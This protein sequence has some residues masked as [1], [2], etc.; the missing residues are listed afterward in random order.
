MYA[1]SVICML[2]T[3]ITL[4]GIIMVVRIR[5]AYESLETIF[6]IDELQFDFSP[7]LYRS[8]PKNV[9][10]IGDSLARGVGATD[11]KSSIS[12]QIHH[13]FGCKVTTIALI[14][15]TTEDY[16]F[17]HI[18]KNI[19]DN[20]D[21]IVV[22]LGGNDVLRLRSTK[23]IIRDINSIC[24][25]LKDRCQ[26]IVWFFAGNVGNIPIVNNIVPLPYIL[27]NKSDSVNKSMSENFNDHEKVTFIS[28]YEKEFLKTP[29]KK[30]S[31]SVDGLHPSNDVYVHRYSNEIIKVI[32]Q[33]Y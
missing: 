30:E 12:Y 10:V 14:G 2:I 11:S 27:R 26:H 1:P 25:I 32:N 31:F 20:Y 28:F 4:L 22:S 21:V 29:L 33:M 19:L 24:S 9:L 7:Q 17:K 23:D 13:K 3:I 5:K 6:K 8:G 15:A 16:Y 18:Y